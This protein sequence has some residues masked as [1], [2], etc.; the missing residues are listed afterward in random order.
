MSRR[1]IFRRAV[2]RKE[3]DLDR[4]RQPRMQ[5]DD[6]YQQHLAYLLVG[7][8]EDGVQVAEEEERGEG[9]AEDDE[10]PVQDCS[11]SS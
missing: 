11:R 9:E 6:Q 8:G 1:L 10:Y 5:S 4:D 3:Q 2:M 7:G